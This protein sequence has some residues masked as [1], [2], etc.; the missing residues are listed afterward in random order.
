M[1]T[2]KIVLQYDGTA[3]AGWQRQANGVAVQAILEDALGPIEGSRV[4]V[5]GAGRTDAGVHALAQ[6]ATVTLGV[7][8][9][10]STLS[11]VA[12]EEVARVTSTPAWFQLYAYRDRSLTLRLVERAEAAGY[13]AVV[14]TVDAPLLGRRERDARNEFALPP[15]LVAA[16]LE[17]PATR[18]LVAAPGESGRGHQRSRTRCALHLFERRVLRDP[19]G[20]QPLPEHIVDRVAR[21]LAL[22]PGE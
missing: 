3:Y 10:L 12:L 17:A 15:G 16:N 5:H 9:V 1:R 6:V 20:P 2:L 19:H 7:T 8:V 18:A 21:R 13:E 14:L 22:P 4:V 11:T